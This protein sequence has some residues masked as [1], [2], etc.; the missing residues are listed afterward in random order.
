MPTKKEI[1]QI[2]NEMLIEIKTTLTELP[3]QND[4]EEVE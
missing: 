1:Q 3:F 2:K 4:D